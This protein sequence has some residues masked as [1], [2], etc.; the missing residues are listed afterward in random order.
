LAEGMNVLPVNIRKEDFFSE[1]I[2]KKN[3]SPKLFEEFVRHFYQ[4][5][6]LGYT[7]LIT[8]Q[9]PNIFLN[10]AENAYDFFKPTPNPENF[11]TQHVT[12]EEYGMQA[13][14]LHGY[15]KRFI[16]RSVSIWLKNQGIQTDELIHP[17]FRPI[18]S[19]NEELIECNNASQKAESLICALFPLNVE[20]AKDY[21][22][23][24]EEI[25]KKLLFV[26]NDFNA[27]EEKLQEI[28]TNYLQHPSEHIRKTGEFIKWLDSEHFVYLGMREYKTTKVSEKIVSFEYP[29]CKTKYGIFKLDKV[30]NEIN[31]IPS[32][33]TIDS[34]KEDLINNHLLHI[35]KKHE[36][37][38]IYR[39]SRIDSI[40]LL[41]IDSENNIIGTIQIIGLF[42]SEFYKASP[43]DVPYLKNKAE[44]VYNLFGFSLASHDGRLLRNIIDSIPLDEFYYLKE[45]QIA[46]LTN[47]VLNMYDK[48]AVFVRNDEFGR[49]VSVLMYMPKH[50]YSE[51]LRLRLGNIV[52]EELGGSITSA[53][54]FVGDTAF[55]RLIYVI[56]FKK[57]ENVN[58][59]EEE[60]EN[61]LWINSQTWTERFEYFCNQIK[62]SPNINFSSAYCQAT[63]PQEASED[64]LTLH[65]WLQKNE[66][67][68]FDIV[69]KD[70]KIIVRVFQKEHALTLGQ[71]MPIFANFQLNVE[72]EKTFFA[73]I[74]NQKVWM[75][76]YEMQNTGHNQISEKTKAKLT[77][78][79]YASWNKIIEVDPFNALTINCE[80]DFKEIIVFRSF[81][82]YLK[83]LGFNYSQRALSDCL[84]S[85]P[86]ITKL[87]I[88]YFY[89][90]FNSEE[91]NYRE[92]STADHELREMIL[93]SFAIVTRL[94]HDRILRKYLNLIDATLRTNAFKN[95]TLCP[96]PV[97]SF[98]FNS[99]KI[100]DIPQP[101]PHAEI[102]IYSPTME[103]CH[104]RGGKIARGGLRWSDR[105]EDFRFEVLGLMKAQMLKNAIIVPLGSKGGFVIKNYNSLKESGTPPAELKK[106]VIQEY[107]TFIENL[108]AITD[109]LIES[110]IVSPQLVH[111]DKEDPYL[112][113]AAD[114]GTA[115]FSDTA[116]SISQKFNF[117]LGD[118]FASGGSKGYDHKKFGITARGAWVAVRRHFWE[119]G[120]DCQTQPISV[121]GV[122]DMSGDV[123]GNGMLQSKQIQLIAAFNHN[124]I[125]LDPNPNTEL[126]YKERENLFAKPYS[127]WNDYDKSCISDG[128]GI[129]DRSLK[130]IEITPQ[131]AEKFGISQNN[132]SPD[133]LISKLLTAQVDLLWFGGIGTFVKSSIE[134]NTQVSDR[135]ND[136]IRIDARK[137]KAKVIGEGA[138]LGVTQLGR[139]EYA[140][141]NGSIN[142]D[143]VDNSAGVSCSD[144]EVNLKIMCQKLIEQKILPE[145]NRDQLLS[146]LGDEVCDL[147][148]EDN[149]AQTLLLS[150]LQEESKNDLDSFIVLI[151]E[152]EEKAVL[153]LRREVEFIPS[154]EDLSRR[155][156]QGQ[157]LT[158]P[159][160]AVI[161]AYTKIHLYQDLMHA[162]QN[163]ACF[164][165]TFYKQYF[166]K[167]FA[168]QYEE[169]LHSHPLKTEITATVLSNLVINVMG[170]CFVGQMTEAFQSDLVE[171]VRVFVEIIEIANFENQRSIYSSL[172]ADFDSTIKTYDAMKLNIM[173]CVM[174][175]LKFP[176]LILRKEY[177]TNIKNSQ[178]PYAISFANE[179]FNF[180]NPNKLIKNYE[181]LSLATLWE[182]TS[183]CHPTT[184]WEV[185][186]W[187]VQQSELITLIVKLCNNNWDEESV[188]EY[189]KI[190]EK[191]QGYMASLSDPKQGLLLTDY[192]VK[193]LS[194]KI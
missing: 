46:V 69:S 132:L 12:Y 38:D 117:W 8:Q 32:H 48:S 18:R 2:N 190:F 151:K 95:N 26:V 165:E 91:N 33:L 179:L 124:H 158:R 181:K 28:E 143:A 79:L 131:V 150:K 52:L 127:T 178:I 145:S 107:S 149:W 76:H 87:L 108:L 31:F 184:G 43:L 162:L 44:R 144:H 187:L 81:G 49:S 116:N 163:S 34:G 105:P 92:K 180:E 139:I 164:G 53:H 153:P 155:K 115:T 40:E 55:A 168:D 172:E 36:R 47:R 136:V 19:T 37:S 146:E 23:Q 9:A 90:L 74:E 103:A 5:V 59:K 100:I 138:N 159:E 67:I 192:I 134:S 126:S 122:G 63:E 25:Y 68:H 11:K 77:E 182:W 1:L 142:M 157:G 112:V 120:I 83:Q 70:T 96:H 171:I 125:F 99:S 21:K 101:T 160:L 161:V 130:S 109:N 56:T 13:L 123:F 4:H 121:I 58:F 29:A 102:F 104:L 176:N 191:C 50:R 78:G 39:A 61:K 7:E 27:T 119:L 51:E 65:L 60:L 111:F 14:F 94:D 135:I 10:I 147:V 193:N 183:K 57:S 194:T 97:I 137:L 175:R 89:Q 15:D 173:Q 154:N 84:S 75:H 16:V 148:L 129:Y 167:V 98:K 114:K 185:A 80:L 128:G 45:E 62:I 22:L 54:G 186:T 35:S 106:I 41:D 166:P 174:L 20:L 72:S 73:D 88:R 133:E 152:L 6:S 30:L 66:S 93:Q 169:F 170:P 3:N 188:K 140:L 110:E 71:I 17:I 113:V 24:L 118:A 85:Y 86:P 64:A 42:T 156:M 177:F 141:N 189:F 82:R